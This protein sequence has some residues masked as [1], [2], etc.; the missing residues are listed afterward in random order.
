MTYALWVVQVLL[1]LLFEFA[2]GMKLVLPLHQLAGPHP[3]PV[4]N[5]RSASS[6]AAS[7]VT[8]WV[9]RSATSVSAPA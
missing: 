8:A 7:Q 2:G 4:R 9:N 1:A 3:L 5:D 6:A